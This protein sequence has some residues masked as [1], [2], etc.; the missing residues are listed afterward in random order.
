MEMNTRPQDVLAVSRWL[1]TEDLEPSGRELLVAMKAEPDSPYLFFATRYSVEGERP[2]HFA[3]WV[4]EMVLF[5]AAPLRV[6]VNGDDLEI[7]SARAAKEAL[8]TAMRTVLGDDETFDEAYTQAVKL[9]KAM[10][11]KELI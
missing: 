2:R 3:G 7:S 11:E 8:R 6:G 9:I 10:R 4:N 5:D 1:T